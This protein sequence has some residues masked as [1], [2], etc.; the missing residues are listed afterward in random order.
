MN[1]AA[2]ELRNPFDKNF[3]RLIFQIVVRELPFVMENLLIQDGISHGTNHKVV[4]VMEQI[5]IAVA[6][7][8]TSP[9]TEKPEKEATLSP[10]SFAFFKLKLNA[11]TVISP[12]C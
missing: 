4:C 9:T 3:Q 6:D 1:I 11:L 7:H 8:E 10:A 5:L 12:F 2:S